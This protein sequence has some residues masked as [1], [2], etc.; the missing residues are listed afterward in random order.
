MSD[1]IRS[2][3]NLEIRDISDTECPVTGN[4]KI[5]IF[6][7]KVKKGDIGIRFY[8]EDENEVVQWEAWAPE[9]I[10]VHRQVAIVFKTPAYATPADVSEPID[11]LLELVRPSDGKRSEPPHS[12]RYVPD[13]LNIDNLT[14]KKEQKITRSDA[15]F[16]FIEQS[17]DEKRKLAIQNPDA[18]VQPLTT[19]STFSHYNQAPN[20]H[21]DQQTHFENRAFSHNDIQIR[22]AQNVYNNFSQPALQIN[23]P[24][25]SHHHHSQFQ[26]QPQ[27]IQSTDGAQMQS[28]NAINP[29]HSQLHEQN[30]QPEFQQMQSHYGQTGCEVYQPDYNSYY[31][32][33]QLQQQYYD[34]S[35][36][37]P[38]PANSGYGGKYLSSAATY[39]PIPNGTCE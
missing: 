23:Q 3:N 18:P 20:N 17:K 33:Q 35:Y 28:H 12:F 6:C 2:R 24:Y 15:L 11:V 39:R 29:S 25:H 5:V 32:Q 37:H 4:K 21:T 30:I 16:M 9:P 36:F 22:D 10:I 13:P 26:L 34:Q 8:R 31:Q 38:M 14:K 19:Q 27:N 7:S 1:I